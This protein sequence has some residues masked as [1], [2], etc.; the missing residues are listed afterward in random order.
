[1]VKRFYRSCIT[2]KYALIKFLLAIGVFILAYFAFRTKNNLFY[3]AGCAAGIALIAVMAVEYL[4]KQ[5]VVRCLKDV[6][7]IE[8]YYQEGALL[9]RTFVLEKRML[10]AD[11]KLH[12]EEIPTDNITVLTIENM[13]KGKQRAILV[14]DGKTCSFLLD[15]TTQAGRLAAFLARKN[16]GIAIQGV[17]PEGE[18]T[19]SLLKRD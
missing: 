19:L 11:E 2:V 16:P 14:R 8:E 12:I 6:K 13:P 3:Y 15:N 9:G 4:H 1:M 10:V 7:Q 18:G 5:K 17:E